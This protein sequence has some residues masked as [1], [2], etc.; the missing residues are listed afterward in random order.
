MISFESGRAS[1]TGNKISAH[2][3]LSTIQFAGAQALIQDSKDNLHLAIHK[4]YV[5]SKTNNMKFFVNKAKV[6]EF[7]VIYPLKSKIVI[8]NIVLGYF[9]ILGCDLTYDDDKYMAIKVNRFETICCTICRTLRIKARKETQVRLYKIMVVPMLLYGS[10][11]WVSRQMDV[12]PCRQQKLSS[13]GRFKGCSRL[14]RMCHDDLGAALDIDHSSTIQD[15][16]EESCPTHVSILN[17]ST[18]IKKC[19]LKW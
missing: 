2:Q 10:K 12:K 3:W 1:F 17:T 6:V 4:L 19:G 9:I 11:Y 7:K 5:L 15:K 8:H 14:D 18:C 13:F 16:L